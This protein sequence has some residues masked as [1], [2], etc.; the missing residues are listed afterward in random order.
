MAGLLGKIRTLVGIEEEYQDEEDY[1]SQEGYD[2]AYDNQYAGSQHVDEEPLT[3][4]SIWD[5][6][7]KSRYTPP[8][9]QQPVMRQRTEKVIPIPQNGQQRLVELT[10]KFNIMVIEPKDFEMCPKLVD[11]LKSKKPVI[12]NLEKIET[13]TAR[14]I[15]D[16]LSGATYALGGDLQ[17]I[18]NNIFVFLPENVDVTTN[19]ERTTGISF[20]SESPNPWKL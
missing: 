9:Q 12:V 15:F 2:R 10:T 7:P 11:S 13:K 18:A 17:K 8:P 19:T 3:R 4:D 6:H 16:F 1:Y 20:G 5:V 14:K